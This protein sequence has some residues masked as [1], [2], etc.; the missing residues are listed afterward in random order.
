[1][2]HANPAPPHTAVTKKATHTTRQPV[3]HT[4]REPSAETGYAP[5]LNAP[6]GGPFWSGRSPWYMVALPYECGSM[7]A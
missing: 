1:M 5:P 7:V 3:T 6:K 4:Q 2:Y